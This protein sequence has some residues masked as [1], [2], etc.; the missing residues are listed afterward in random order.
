MLSDIDVI[1]SVA[2]ITGSVITLL[3]CLW[4]TDEE[5]KDFETWI[6]IVVATLLWPLIL[7]G[8]LLLDKPESRAGD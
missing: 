7:L 8:M 3:V 5:K 1:M 6:G 4:V 2:Y